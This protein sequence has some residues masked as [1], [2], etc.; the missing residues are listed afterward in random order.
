M[1]DGRSTKARSASAFVSALAD[2]STGVNSQ[3]TQT[4]GQPPTQQPHACSHAPRRVYRGLKSFQ[5]H[6]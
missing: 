4:V 2:H 5:S 3:L 6:V 1:G